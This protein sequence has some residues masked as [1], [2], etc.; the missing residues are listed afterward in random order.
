MSK[1][2]N[3]SAGKFSTPLKT[4]VRGITITYSWRNITNHFK[5]SKNHIITDYPRLL[6]I[7]LKEEY[8][9]SCQ[10]SFRPLENP[11]KHVGF[12]GWRFLFPQRKSS[13]FL[14]Q[15]KK[16]N[17]ISNFCTQIYAHTFQ[18]TFLTQRNRDQREIESQNESV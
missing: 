1:I 6:F 14:Y 13:C 15:K 17:F 12:I 16:L 7:Y 5:T 18:Q 3:V 11:K 4:N 2:R 10:L 8:E 9:T